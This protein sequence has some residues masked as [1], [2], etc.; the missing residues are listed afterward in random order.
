[1]WK[2]Q[3]W[4]LG[5]FLGL[6]A[7]SVLSDPA[8][9]VTGG[10]P[11]A[12]PDLSKPGSID[13]KNWQIAVDPQQRHTDVTQ[14]TGAFNSAIWKNDITCNYVGSIGAFSLKS[15]FK[16]QQPKETDTSWEA[17][18]SESADNVPVTQHGWQLIG[19]IMVCA[20]SDPLK[21]AFISIPNP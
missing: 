1:M 14:V 2:G 12:C 19:Y 11:T 16:T 6:A 3:Q 18:K 5:L 17:K 21:C 4:F 7:T 10:L 8:A 13:V 15:Q 20:D 9:P